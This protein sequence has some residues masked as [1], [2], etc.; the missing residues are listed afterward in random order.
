[1][2]RLVALVAVLA[3]VALGCSDDDGD[4]AA[5]PTT[6]PQP[7]PDGVMR[8][9]MVGPTTFD[10]AAAEPTNHADLIVADLLFD[11]LTAPGADGLG[12]VPA[13]AAALEPDAERR[14]WTVRLR[15]D[16]VFGDGTAVR[17]ADVKSS[18]ER[19]A[20]KGSAS[21]AASRLDVVE[22][23]RAFAVDRTA[24]GLSGVV[25][26][27]DTT[28]TIT[29]REPYAELPG[30]LSSPLYG[31]VPADAA[32]AFF[33]APRG[34]GPFSVVADDG[35][36]VSLTRQDG[37]A[38]DGISLTTVQLVRSA[39]LDA[40]YATFEDGGL[41][42]TLLPERALEEADVRWGGRYAPAPFGVE[43]WLG[44]ELGDPRY[45]DVR[46]RQAVLHAID[47]AAIVDDVLPGRLL[48]D[49]LV[50]VGVP[51][52]STGAGGS[53]GDRCAFDPDRS[54][55]LLTE[56][57]PAGGAPTVVLSTFDDPEQRELGAAVQADLEAVGLTVTVDVRPL[58]EYQA[59][60]PGERPLFSFGWVGLVPTPESYLGPL[61]LS[62]S[63]DN[64]TGFSDPAVDLAITAAR[65]T[66]DP[67]EREGRYLEVE[68]TVL[69]EVP[70]IPLA[71]VVTHQVVGER[72]SGFVPRVDGTFELSGLS[73]AG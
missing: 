60:A 34:S 28:L 11:G 25:V 32:D 13:L 10:P 3:L 61:F 18:L 53:C 4:D 29:T 12:A 15:T 33:A 21:I 67:R 57:Y 36:T 38:A 14:V 26:V 19:I 17:A 27:D 73:A 47:R 64:A 37:P 46:F 68:Q 72:V 58:A 50:P 65:G 52:S 41:D 6:G 63:P 45:Q 16:A 59:L 8:L 66:A 43:L 40:S 22:G 24:Q 2:A 44:F 62:G 20:A 31:V 71:Q 39:D 49:G 51:G 69:S 70:V 35:T 30:L 7:V 5:P 1:M 9:G 48:L 42:W 54:R 55:A 56:A 23:Y